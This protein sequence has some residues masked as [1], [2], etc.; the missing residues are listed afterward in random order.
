MPNEPSAIGH[1]L[2]LAERSSWNSND[3]LLQV[4]VE[5]DL[6][7]TVASETPKVFALHQKLHQKVIKGPMRVLNDQLV[8]NF[9]QVVHRRCNFWRESLVKVVFARHHVLNREKTI[10]N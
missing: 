3:G 9:Q 7:Q 5:Q 6:A 8:K 1:H 2:P 10:V 4:F